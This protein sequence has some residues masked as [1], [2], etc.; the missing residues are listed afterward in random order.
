MDRT[1]SNCIK[2]F[3]IVCAPE[4]LFGAD[5]VDD[6]DDDDN[7]DDN[8][9]DD[10]D[11]LNSSLSRISTHDAFWSNR[12][13]PAPISQLFKNVLIKKLLNATLSFNSFADY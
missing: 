2:C 9:D 5:D 13:A 10:D 4:R 3:K 6:D 8:N 7:N 11:Q 1:H 12:E